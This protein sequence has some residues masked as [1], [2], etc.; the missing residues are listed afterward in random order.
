[1]IDRLVDSHFTATK[2]KFSGMIPLMINQR[3]RK[4]EFGY[5]KVITNPIL[6]KHSFNLNK[7]I[8]IYKYELP[9]MQQAGHQTASLCVL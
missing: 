5:N 1:M 6:K 4:N 3:K 2:N 7:F 9:K 8:I